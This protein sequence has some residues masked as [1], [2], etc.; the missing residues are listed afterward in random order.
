V[1]GVE[2]LVTASID[3]PNTGY[4]SI[5]ATWSPDGKK[6]AFNHAASC[7]SG[8]GIWV[9][10][11]LPTIGNVSQLTSS[12]T[13]A[14]WSPDG[15]N[16][17]FGQGVSG[18]SKITLATGVVSQVISS[19]VYEP[20]YSPDGTRIV[21]TD[22]ASTLRV[23]TASVSDPAGTK[24]ALTTTSGYVRPAWSPD[25]TKVAMW[26]HVTGG[27]WTINAN[28][29]G[30]A[31]LT[32]G[33]ATNSDAY[34][35]WGIARLTIQVEIDI[36]PGSFPNSI[37]RGSNGNVP[38]ALLSSSTFDATTA[39]PR[40]VV[41]AG[42]SPLNIGKTLEDVNGDGRLDLVLHFATQSLDLPAGTTEAC[43]SGKTIG[44][45]SFKGCDSVRL[46]K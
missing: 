19:V 43:L 46:V 38:V 25:G 44:A 35:W 24:T 39:D 30:L 17:L 23:Y 14:S 31:R 2:T 5:Y 22:P 3:Y 9:T 29:T 21:W 18:L 20:K 32:T 36:K 13:W 42:A 28:G 26:N 12:G 6:I 41:F 4:A 34:P 16:I 10:D 40:T 27:I 1:T 8:G 15:T 33:V 7:G 11:Y 45:D 37:N